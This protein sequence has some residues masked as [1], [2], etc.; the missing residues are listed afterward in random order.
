[1]ESLNLVFPIIYIKKG[2]TNHGAF[3]ILHKLSDGT[4]VRQGTAKERVE[5]KI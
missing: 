3:A 5:K 4:G 2:L 1:M